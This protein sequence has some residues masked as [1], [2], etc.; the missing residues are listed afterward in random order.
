[1]NAIPNRS[2]LSC[3]VPAEISRT[4]ATILLIAVAFGLSGPAHSQIRVGVIASQSGPLAPVGLEIVRG[5]GMAQEK[6]AP[7][8]V[9]MTCDDQGTPERAVVCAKQLI[10]QDKVHAIIGPGTAATQ[11]AVIGVLRDAPHVPVV[12]LSAVPLASDQRPRNFFRLRGTLGNALSAA[13][14]YIS[15][16]LKAQKI[17]VIGDASLRIGDKAGWSVMFKTGAIAFDAKSFGESESQRFRSVAPAAVLLD[18]RLAQSIPAIRRAGS[19]VPIIVFTARGFDS[20]RNFKD[21]QLYVVGPPKYPTEAAKGLH[22]EYEKKFGAPADAGL[23]LQAASAVQ[24]IQAALQKDGA[25]STKV[26]AEEKFDTVLG[27]ITFAKNGDARGGGT[28]S[29]VSKA[30]ESGTTTTTASTSCKCKDADCCKTDC[31]EKAG[32]NSAKNVC[33]DVSCTNG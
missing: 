23:L 30:S 16:E 29:T 11:Q 4:A 18:D 22:A 32:C 19:Q 25:I 13:A 20:F 15:N 31:C 24:V 12:S 28:G 6:F 1:M 21:P 14:D 10:E 7:K 26:L 3:S 5:I 8:T 17:G 9:F 2:D 27:S 33:K